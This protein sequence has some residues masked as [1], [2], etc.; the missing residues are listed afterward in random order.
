MREDH[1]ERPPLGQYC[2]IDRTEGLP[3]LESSQVSGAAI[4]QEWHVSDSEQISSER[5]PITNMETMTTTP[6][7]QCLQPTVANQPAKNR[8]NWQ[9][10]PVLILFHVG[11]VAALF[12]FTWPALLVALFLYWVTG[13]LGLGIG[14]HR[15]LTHRSYATPKWFEYFLTI[16]G[17]AAL[18]GGPLLWVAIHRKHHQFADK[19]GDPHSP[20]DGKWWAHAGWVL[21]GNALRQDVATL[22]RYVPDLAEDRVHVWLTKYH[23]VPTAVLGLILFAIGGFRLVL[24]GTFFRTVVGLHATWIV[25]SVAHIWG[26]RR[27]K[28][29]DTSTNNW[30]VALISFGDGWHNNHH[31]YPVSARHGFKWYEIDFNWYAIWIFKQLGLV[32]HIRRAELSAVKQLGKSLVPVE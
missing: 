1:R 18:E 10:A 17:V 21:F 20:R 16:C 2:S 31:A 11:A 19:D 3:G 5:A 6:V 12:F 24:W 30:W 29:R 8:L 22:K 25:N 13:G 7:L 14:Y 15:L 23:L 26:T 32:S 9:A 28:T 27:F 4:A